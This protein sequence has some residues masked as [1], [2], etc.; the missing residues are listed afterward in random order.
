MGKQLSF[1][2]LSNDAECGEAILPMTSEFCDE[3]YDMPTIIALYRDM[4][5]RDDAGISTSA[6]EIHDQDFE[7][8][9]HQNLGMIARRRNWQALE[10]L[11]YLDSAEEDKQIDVKKLVYKFR[12]EADMLRRK[13]SKDGTLY[14]KEP[15]ER[16]LTAFYNISRD[17]VFSEY[18]ANLFNAGF[19]K[20]EFLS[21]LISFAAVKRGKRNYGSAYY[22][23]SLLD[24]FAYDTIGNT[25]KGME[26]LSR[27][28][29]GEDLLSGLRKSIFMDSAQSAFKRYVC[30]DGQSHRIN[31]SRHDDSLTAF[32]VDKLSSTEEIKPIRLFEKTASYIRN[33]LGEPRDSA[34]KFVVKICIIGHTEASRCGDECSLMDYVA[35][36]LNWYGK[37][38]AKLDKKPKPTL[39]LNVTNI[40]STGDWPGSNQG[41]PRK[42]FICKLEK[43]EK[44][45][46]WAQCVIKKVDYENTFGLNTMQL[47]K[48][49][50]DNDLIFL[51]DCPWLSTENFDIK[52][53]GSLDMFCRELSHHGRS[54]ETDVKAD[55][56][57]FV[58]NAHSFYKNSVFRVID[59]QY[60]RIMAS[61][62]T[63]SGEIIR[64]MKDHLFRRVNKIF[65]DM[66]ENRKEGDAQ[67]RKTLYIFTSEKDGIKYS[68][69]ASYHLTRQEKY[70]GRSHTIIRFDNNVP[71]SMEYKENTEIKFHANLWS[72]LKYISVSYAYLDFKDR[73]KDCLNIGDQ[74]PENAISYFELYRNIEIWFS[75]SRNLRHI[76]VTTGFKEGIDDCIKDFSSQLSD[77]DII[78]TREK[79]FKTVVSLLE[80]LYTESVFKTNEHYGDDAI[81]TAFSTNL[82]SCI[83]N[84]NMMLFWH[85]Y[86]TA[87]ERGRFDAFK[88]VFDPKME[89]LTNT[90]NSEFHD[91]DF[92]MDKKLYDSTMQTLE[93]T[94]SMTL[95][96]RSMFIDAV[97][98]YHN[99]NA[100]Y[101]VLNNITRACEDA[102]YTDTGLYRNATRVLRE[103]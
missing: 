16:Y 15:A 53:S 80:P 102:G 99:E 72:I 47:K 29:R 66:R 61:T 59:S 1:S 62:T 79:L 26:L 75:V 10:K 3:N 89:S 64:V 23:Y 13:L 2:Y 91:R 88:V 73:I 32:P 60:N 100:M 35:A 93:Q 22:E 18:N 76:T 87:C 33:G 9:F 28:I 8:W 7:T 57:Q 103:G 71:K 96:L 85:K 25:I 36:V 55:R 44:E 81:K 82:Y 27:D 4:L 56:K 92:F 90:D 42:S 94:T 58:N 43:D 46:H 97:K 69:F 5:E 40:V 101:E 68:Y 21:A 41:Y 98:L 19:R 37:L 6:Y 51:L 20:S 83:N 65:K 31:L 52:Q 14:I 48:E 45:E 50:E 63:K 49:I 77:S 74:E 34:D 39:K 38:S 84:V 78:N 67:K 54:A 30:L 11:S 86:R 17:A 24:P 95:G 12:D 70:D